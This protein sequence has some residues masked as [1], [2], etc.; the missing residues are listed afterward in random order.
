MDKLFNKIFKPELIRLSNGKSIERKR[1]IL[2]FVALLVVGFTLL[3][4]HIT[5]FNF[6]IFAN[7]SNFFQILIGM[8]HLILA[9]RAKYGNLLSIR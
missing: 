3:S 9:I 5:G 1:S 8:I 7:T 6:K 4:A 2:P